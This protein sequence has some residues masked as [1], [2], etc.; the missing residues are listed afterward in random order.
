MKPRS[1]SARPLEVVI[2][3]SLLLVLTYLY[4]WYPIIENKYAFWGGKLS[5]QCLP[6]TVLVSL[7]LKQN[8]SGITNVRYL[9]DGSYYPF[10]ILLDRVA[11]EYNADAFF[12]L[13]E[14]SVILHYFFAAISMYA[15]AR[16]GFKIN[17]YGALLS[18]IVFTYSGMRVA[19]IVDINAV[20]SLAW[21]P[22][23]YL[24]LK[25][26]VTHNDIKRLVLAAAF[27][28]VILLGGDVFISTSATVFAIFVLLLS[29]RTYGVNGPT[30]LYIG[31]MG[32]ILFLI[33]YFSSSEALFPRTGPW[34]I[35]T[36]FPYLIFPQHAPSGWWQYTIYIGIIPLVFIPLGIRSV[37]CYTSL[38]FK[39]IATSTVL[40]I[41]ALL[42][43]GYLRQE[44]HTGYVYLTKSR[45]I[46][47]MPLAILAGIGCSIFAEAMHRDEKRG[48]FKYCVFLRKLTLF[49]VPVITPLVYALLVFAIKKDWHKSL[50]ITATNSMVWVLIF[51]IAITVI[52]NLR[53]T[54]NGRKYLF[55]ILFLTVIDIFTFWSFFDPINYGSSEMRTVPSTSQ[56]IRGK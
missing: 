26:W 22:L 19:H 1:N 17:V 16:V 46:V 20:Y 41:F 4:F 14:F 54:N 32:V 49:I 42:L 13:L 21:V 11:N 29:S 6:T 10:N 27:S 53:L 48:F 45:F 52:F 8:D 34:S 35:L 36:I 7:G 33:N 50:I 3:A 31:T 39:V 15:L 56:Y 2:V 38:T 9:L 28:F 44:N 40:T 12:R 43:V 47:S 51:L 30:Y 55:L 37:R 25:E 24:F 18:S 23:Y 5:T